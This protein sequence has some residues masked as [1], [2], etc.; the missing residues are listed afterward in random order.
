[1]KQR[2]GLFGTM[3]AAGLVLGILGVQLVPTQP[4]APEEPAWRQ[5]GTVATAQ[6]DRTYSYVDYLPDFGR[7]PLHLANWSASLPELPELPPLPI[8]EPEPP[9]E[10]AA[11]E[12]YDTLPLDP[13]PV[14]PVLARSSPH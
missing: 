13:P 1:V 12:D 8:P 2:Q 4:K 9:A 5:F 14:I 7:M 10:W 6:P 3:A 11:A